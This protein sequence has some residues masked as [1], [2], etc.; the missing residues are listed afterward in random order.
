MPTFA[1]VFYLVFGIAIFAYGEM[2][3]D[4][5]EVY[6]FVVVTVVYFVVMFGSLMLEAYG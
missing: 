3:D 6:A 4:G 1:I 5:T 2:R